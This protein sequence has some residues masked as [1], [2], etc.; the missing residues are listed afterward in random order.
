MASHLLL[1]SLLALPPPPPSP[2]CSPE[3]L[4][5]LLS[6]LFSSLGANCSAYTALFDQS[7]RYYHQHDGFRPYSRLA[8]NCE[9]YAATCP[10]GRCTFRQHG[11]ASARAS[12]DGCE[13]LA[14]YLWAQSPADA[15][16][17]EPHTGWEYLRLVRAEG[18]AHGF[19]IRLFAELETSYSVAYHWG[20]PAD[21]S[22]YEWT[23]A[24]L[25]RRGSAS[26]GECGVPVVGTLAAY[27]AGRSAG[28][29]TMRQQG[30]A[31]VLAAGWNATR[32]FEAQRC[33][34][35]APYALSDGELS[36]GVVVLELF[37]TGGAYNLLATSTFPAEV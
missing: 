35:A 3:S 34:V 2:A 5:P 31:V 8:Q 16:N 37:P 7:A 15:S 36:T 13:L 23:T 19:R 28:G 18:A 22:A 21:A 14:P 26:R 24:L 20:Q 29:A 33:F 27:F 12:A 1:P 32:R 6:T 30:D 17:L 25:A 4:A 10:A 9:A 11:R